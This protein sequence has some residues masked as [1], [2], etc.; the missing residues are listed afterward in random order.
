M[1]QEQ[2]E[3]ELPKIII[4]TQTY[5]VEKYIQTAIKSVLA[6]TYKNW[7]W[8]LIE[9]AST[10]GT[11]EVIET[12]L[13]K[14][15]DS[16]IHYLKQKYNTLLEPEKEKNI[17]FDEVLPSLVGKGYYITALD[18]DD[19]FTPRALE[20]MVQPVL[21]HN[22]DLVITGRQPFSE[23]GW[24]APQLPVNRV[25]PNISDLADVWTKNYQSMRAMWSKLFRLDGFCKARQNPIIRGMQNGN[26]TMTN[27][28]YMQDVSSAA[29]VDEITVNFCIRENSV[30]NSNVYPERYRSYIKIY[31]KTI[32]LFRQ[33]RRM[34]SVNLHF[35]VLVLRTSMIETIR[36]TTRDADAP[37]ALL[38]I[39]NIL[40]DETVYQ[41]L[42]KFHLYDDLLKEMFSLLSENAEFSGGMP[43]KE[44]EN[45]FHIWLLLA[46]REA[47]TDDYIALCCLLRGVLD[48]K[49]R[50]RV[51]LS[52]L[53]EKLDGFL[54]PNARSVFSAL[55]ASEHS[56]RM[57]A[58]PLAY[59]AAL[60]RDRDRLQATTAYEKSTWAQTVLPS[61]KEQADIDALRQ[62][63]LAAM[64]A[65]D[66]ATF[67]TA[68]D[69]LCRLSPFDYGTMYVKMYSLCLSGQLEAAA[70]VASLIAYLHPYNRLLID[71]AVMIFDETG[72]TEAA[73]SAYQKYAAFAPQE[74]QDEIQAQI[75]ARQ[76]ALQ[77]A[78]EIELNA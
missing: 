56:S 35:S 1:N 31:E 74:E 78:Q 7:E 68:L 64:Q 12:F 53:R 2:N 38:L 18:S 70:C 77:N 47:S 40:T 34:D 63:T 49:N 71:T 28:L 62:E 45:Y 22:V 44:A 67:V 17:L 3:Q 43:K 25:F 19:Y 11:A 52:F 69:R 5:N 61:E 54:A 6:Q 26:D 9:N 66:T 16:R 75:A 14:H 30:F 60:C 27:L 39:Q 42:T 24:Y 23:K 51:G 10:D 59:A 46:M 36:P 41:V 32:E 55:T 76:A 58:N 13:K 50:Y 8:Y 37:N 4:W 15:P 21:E 29:S 48:G 20:I 33:W 57:D 73:L 72:R 65:N